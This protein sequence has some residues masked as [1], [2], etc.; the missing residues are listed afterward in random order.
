[1]RK[2]WTKFKE[3]VYLVGIV[4]IGAGWF[5]QASVSKKMNEL[6]DQAQDAQIAVQEARIHELESENQK[7]KGYAKENA[8]NIV[9]LIRVF[10]L[11][12]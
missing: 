7:I 12:E 2:W 9:W 1:M 4:G 6:K 10:E 8:D 11:S 5:I 3:A